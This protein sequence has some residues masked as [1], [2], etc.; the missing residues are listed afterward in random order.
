[1]MCVRACVCVRDIFKYIRKGLIY[2]LIIYTLKKANEK[3]NWAPLF[4]HKPVLVLMAVF[5]QTAW[6]AP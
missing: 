5:A 4:N 2:S 6:C 1:M 3:S